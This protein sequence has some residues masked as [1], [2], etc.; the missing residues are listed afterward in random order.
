MM[1]A[2]FRSLLFLSIASLGP[3]WAQ[4]DAHFSQYMF[5]TLN[6]NPA[7]AGVANTEFTLIHR[8]QWLGYSPTKYS[9]T[10]PTSQYFG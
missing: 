1:G 10:A 5:S 9:G 2:L 7:Y 3:L 8:S 4:Q 6:Y